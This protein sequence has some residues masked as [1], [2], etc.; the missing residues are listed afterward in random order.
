[1][2]APPTAAVEKK[3]EKK[4]VE[5]NENLGKKENLEKKENPHIPRH[6]GVPMMGMDLLAEMK[7][8]QGRMAGKKVGGAQTGSTFIIVFNTII[9]PICWYQYAWTYSMMKEHF[10]Q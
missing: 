6:I 7:A 1:M 9:N 10:Q 5:N 3:E 4:N 2:E 8:R